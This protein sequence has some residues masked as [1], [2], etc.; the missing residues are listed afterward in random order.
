MEYLLWSG[1]PVFPKCSQ[2]SFGWSAGI[3]VDWVELEAN[4]RS[5]REVQ[6]CV[7]DEMSSVDLQRTSDDWNKIEKRLAFSQISI[8]D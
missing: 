6:G 8:I 3:Q 1:R 5:I 4:V 2:L 7:S